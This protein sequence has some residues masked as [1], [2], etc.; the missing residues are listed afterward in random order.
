[1]PSALTVFLPLNGAPDALAK[2]FAADPLLWLPLSGPV[3]SGRD[4]SVRLWVGDERLT[5]GC[6]VEPPR[7][8]DGGLARSFRL[9]ANERTA[10]DGQ[11]PEVD[12]ELSLRPGPGGRPTLLLRARYRSRCVGG[13]RRDLAQLAAVRFLTE[14]VA[15]LEAAADSGAVTGR[16]LHPSASR[17]S[18][19]SSRRRPAAIRAVG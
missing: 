6:A 5:A 1:M 8:A 19:L 11:S 4:W 12:G 13:R 2:V 3:R 18:S 16:H 14:V 17:R 15:R 7:Y 10:A 9:E